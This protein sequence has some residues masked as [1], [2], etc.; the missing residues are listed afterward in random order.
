MIGSRAFASEIA[1]SRTTFLRDVTLVAGRSLVIRSLRKLLARF[2]PI[3]WEYEPKSGKSNPLPLLQSLEEGIDELEQKTA[4]AATTDLNN[5]AIEKIANSLV[6]NAFKLEDEWISETIPIAQVRTAAY[7]SRLSPM[8]K[9]KTLIVENADRMKDEARNSLL[10]LLEEPPESISIILTVQRKE[11]VLPT[12]LSRLRPYRFILRTVGEEREIIRRIFKDSQAAAEENAAGANPHFAASGL[13]AAYLSS[14][15]PQPPQKLEPLA[16]F[17]VAA[18]ARSAAVSVRGNGA[19]VSP[20]LNALGGYCA[21]IAEAAGFERPLEA[22]ETIAVLLS[23]SSNFEGRSFP[24]FLSMAL[25][26]VSRSLVQCGYGPV[27]V[28]CREAWRSRLAQAQTATGI[29]N[30][31]PELALESLF[32]RLKEDLA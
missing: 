17:F 23:R 1:A 32:C 18:V 13:V 29:W 2:S 21:P 4:D 20:A 14:F 26:L 25:D 27:P 12:I 10:K 9:R 7:W 11:T 15:S 5:A 31:R 16:A 8:G 3:V 6:S 30:Q 22:K 19:A 28:A 24:R